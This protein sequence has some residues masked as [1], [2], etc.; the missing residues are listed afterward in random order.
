MGLP[1]IKNYVETAELDKSLRLCGS[2]Q[3]HL[4]TFFY[5]LTSLIFQKTGFFNYH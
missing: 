1:Q 3:L 2:Y 4:Q 5:L